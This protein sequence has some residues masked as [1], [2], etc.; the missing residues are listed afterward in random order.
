MTKPHQIRSGSLS[1][2]LSDIRSRK[3]S[4][5]AVVEDGTT[6]VW[7]PIGRGGEWCIVRHDS[8]GRVVARY[9]MG[10]VA[11]SKNLELFE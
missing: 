3:S 6:L 2:A 1:R 8:E 7:G 4:G 10:K 9:K 5:H 11:P